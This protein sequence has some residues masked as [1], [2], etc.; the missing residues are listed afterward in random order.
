MKHCKESGGGELTHMATGT[1]IEIFA[2]MNDVAQP[3]SQEHGHQPSS[4]LDSPDPSELSE[5]G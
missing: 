1:S 2:S 5:P 3:G 4:L